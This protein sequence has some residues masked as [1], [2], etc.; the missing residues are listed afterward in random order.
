MGG[1]EDAGVE[2]AVEDADEGAENVA[3]GGV[4]TLEVGVAGDNSDGG[5]D[6]VNISFLGDVEVDVDCVCPGPDVADRIGRP[7]INVFSDEDIAEPL[8]TGAATVLRNTLE[9]TD[10]FPFICG[11]IAGVEAVDEPELDTDAEAVA[12]IVVF[13]D[14]GGEAEGFV[15]T[16]LLVDDESL[17][18]SVFTVNF[19]AAV[20]LAVADEEPFPFF[21]TSFVSSFFSSAFTSTTVGPDLI[22]ATA[23]TLVTLDA[24]LCICG[25]FG[26]IHNL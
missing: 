2:N 26:G 8:F 10:C 25:G 21:C 14:I 22:S 3:A 6:N 17:G 4:E 1:T 12:E 23:W 18:A 19:D 7:E 13:A 15:D 20:R 5:I 24:G 9:E 16:V 11:D